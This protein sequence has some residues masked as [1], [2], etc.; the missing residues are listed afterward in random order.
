MSRRKSSLNRREA[1]QHIGVFGVGALVSA[2]G[3]GS[4]GGKAT[5]VPTAASTP[6]PSAAPG[7]TSSPTV[8]PTVRASSTAAAS[9]TPTPLPST[10][11]AVQ[12]SATPTT[13]ATASA[14]ASATATPTPSVTPGQ[15]SCVLT[16]Q[17]TLG[18][19]FIDVG[20]ARTDIRE[21]RDGIRLRLSL[22]LV[23]AEGC[24]PIRDAVVH[25][26][27]ADAA[28]AYSGF[29]NQP[30]GIDTTGEIFL[31]GFQMTDADGG[32]EFT[33][34]YP[35]WYTGR[36]VHIHVRIYL[37]ATTVLVSQLYFPDSLTALVHTR[38]PYSERGQP[39]TTNQTD[40]IAQNG[41][42]DL[43]LDIVEEGDGYAAS[44]ILGAG[45]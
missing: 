12:A 21:D 38:A 17:Q 3:G 1:L 23:D 11:T 22:R 18:P 8:A 40:S 19:F 24:A 41:L 15:V 44:I 14:T 4:G 2:C 30:G 26:W 20:L 32:V 34:I 6:T 7:L 31:R 29:P 5:L 45:I 28:G 16:P 13:P 36:T 35:G 25:V 37:D 39:S 10:A 9:A 27:H 42:E 33:T 43:L